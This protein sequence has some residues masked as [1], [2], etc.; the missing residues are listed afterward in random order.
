MGTH[1]AAMVVGVVVGLFWANAI[2]STSWYTRYSQRRFFRRKA[3]EAGLTPN[4]KNVVEVPP[5]P[6]GRPGYTIC[7]PSVPSNLASFGTDLVRHDF[8]AMVGP[9]TFVEAVCLSP[10]QSESSPEQSA[11]VA[12]RNLTAHGIE[13]TDPVSKSTMAGEPAI[14]YAVGGT[15]WA[16]VEWQFKRDGWL[17]AVGI[18][19][20]APD[21]EAHA[22]ALLYLRTW[23]W[24]S[25]GDT[26]S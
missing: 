11:Q 25:A 13:L 2:F 23:Q 12:I 18:R 3:K 4:G 20:V 8:L 15:G 17:F 14:T 1:F 7:M 21:Q 26:Q 24:L 5:G 6:H 19:S 16:L 22:R 10:T 9:G